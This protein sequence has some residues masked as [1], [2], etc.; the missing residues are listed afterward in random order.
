MNKKGVYFFIIDVVI[1]ILI[2]MVTVLLITGF[3]TPKQ[4]ISGL[5]QTLNILSTDF[6]TM[7]VSKLSTNITDN[8]PSEY[9]VDSVT[10]DEYIYLLELNGNHSFARDIVVEILG[11]WPGN[12]GFKYFIDTINK[13]VYEV[14]TPLGLSLNDSSISLSRSKVTVLNTYPSFTN[15]VLSEVTVWD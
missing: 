14:N 12:Y 13:T 9:L 10:V 1:A 15:P 6:F 5:D 4:S 7:P 8:I 2:F 11:Y 3:F